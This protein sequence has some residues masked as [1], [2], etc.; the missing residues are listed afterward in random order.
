MGVCVA[1]NVEYDRKQTKFNKQSVLSSVLKNVILNQPRVLTT[2]VERSSVANRGFTQS[3]PYQLARNYVLTRV[4]GVT[5]ALKMD[6]ARKG[7]P[8][9]D[10][11]FW[12]EMLLLSRDALGTGLQ[13][14]WEG[15]DE[16]GN[17]II[18]NKKEEGN[19]INELEGIVVIRQVD[20]LFI[21]IIREGRMQRTYRCEGVP[22]NLAPLLLLPNS[23]SEEK[24]WELD[25]V[26]RL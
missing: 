14:E 16:E 2:I 7:Q 8:G 19:M 1:G 22:F 5:W 6:L 11:S 21:T 24:G 25:D 26:C 18:E 20:P 15:K 13:K 3:L 23:S 12:A 4:P 10:G 9:R 17:E